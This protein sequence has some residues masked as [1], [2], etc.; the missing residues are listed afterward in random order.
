MAKKRSIDASSWQGTISYDSPASLG[1]QEDKYDKQNA[2]KYRKEPKD[3][4]PSQVLCENAAY[5]AL[6]I[7]T[8]AHVC[9]EAIIPT[10]G[11][12]AGPNRMPEVA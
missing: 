12:N 10:V 3:A 9:T 1:K 11:P 6:R 7:S 4:P 5:T 2:C 8:C